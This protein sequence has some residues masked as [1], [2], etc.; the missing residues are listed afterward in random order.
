MMQVVGPPWCSVCGTPWRPTRPEERDEAYPMLMAHTP[1]CKC[2]PPQWRDP[3]RQRRLDEFARAALIG[4]AAR[5]LDEGGTT[6]AGIATDAYKL[7]EAMLAESARRASAQKEE[8][9]G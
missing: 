8:G 6:P 2:P 5:W 1:Q 9:N 4:I 3:E 7:A